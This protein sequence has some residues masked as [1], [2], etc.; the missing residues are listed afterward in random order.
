MELELDLVARVSDPPQGAAS[1]TFASLECNERTLCVSSR[2]PSV[3][4]TPNVVKCAAV[5]REKIKVLRG[6]ADAY[7]S[8][9]GWWGLRLV[10]AVSG[11]RI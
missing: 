7:A 10:S 1:R 11:L 6:S 5:L 4:R 2:F 3:Q 8:P 9:Q